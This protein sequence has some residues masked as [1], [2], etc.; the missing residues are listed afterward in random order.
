MSFE[1]K[2][3]DVGEGIQ[4]GHVVKWHVKVG[5]KVREDDKLV[6]METDKAVVEIPSPKAGVIL[7]IN[8]TEGQTVKVGEVI[9]VIGEKNERITRKP[10]SAE[11]PKS[12]AVV[13]ELEEAPEDDEKPIK[14]TIKID[15]PEKKIGK[16][17]LATPKVRKLA[18]E[19]GVDINSLSGT[20]PNGRVIEDDVLHAIAG[21]KIA[22]PT[23]S[24]S[25]IKH[26]RKYDFYGYVDRIPLTSVRKIV[27]ENMA[28]S[29]YTAPHVVHMDE[30]DV[31]DLAEIREKEKKKAEAQGIKLTFLPFI[32]KAVIEGLREYPYLNSSLEDNEIVLKKYYNIG[33]AVDTEAGLIVPVVKGADQ[34]NML[35]I[36]KEI[37]DLGEKARKRALDLQDMKGGTFTITNVGS[38]GGMF[39]TPIIN[40]GE[41]AILALG[42]IQEKP[43]VIEGEIKIRKVLP[44]SLSFDH[45]ILD[46]ATAARFGNLLKEHLEDPYKLLMEM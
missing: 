25:G 41:A 4:E 13:G 44:F 32:I 7:Q 19:K 42:R 39:A 2:F 1:F 30:A 45:R 27:A 6:S 16:I 46:G 34:K 24:D 36:A 10:V 22:I 21:A 43:L 28:K 31:T 26:V 35:A 37:Q 14:Q 9:V 29:L 8:F 20:G 18:K 23:P 17:S 12:V 11:R 38:I 5:D 40:P 33:I 15:V 3:P